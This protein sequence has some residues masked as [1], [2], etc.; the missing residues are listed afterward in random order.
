MTHSLEQDSPFGSTGEEAVQKLK[1][2]YG[3]WREKVKGRPDLKVDLE[4]VGAPGLDMF[5]YFDDYP[6]DIEFP[7][8]QCTVS[9][10]MECW[11]R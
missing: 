5:G 6:R 10:W 8:S 3:A 11:R 2:R 9:S 7:A 1:S 4:E